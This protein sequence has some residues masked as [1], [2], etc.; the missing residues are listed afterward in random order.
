M[1]TIYTSHFSNL[2]NA[3]NP[4][5][6]A[7]GCPDFYNGPQFKKLAPKYT[8][9]KQWH[10]EKLSNEWYVEKYNKTVLQTLKPAE[11]FSELFEFYPGA[12]TITIMCWEKPGLF[13]H[14]HLIGEWLSKNINNINVKELQ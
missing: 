12:D 10:D 13:C 3:I 6:I 1:K 11:I 5:S 9:W 7:G 2:K 14:R 4:I 8:W